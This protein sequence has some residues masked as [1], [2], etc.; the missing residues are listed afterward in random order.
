M[1][2]GRSP[3]CRA[4]LAGDVPGVRH[5]Q[6]AGGTAPHRRRKPR[7]PLRSAESSVPSPRQSA[8]CIPHA[9]YKKV[10][11]GPS[12]HLRLRVSPRGHSPT[13]DALRCS[14]AAE[15]SRR[16]GVA[17]GVATD[18]AHERIARHQRESDRS[19]PRRSRRR[20][21]DNRC[22]AARLSTARGSI[23]RRRSHPATQ[24]RWSHAPDV[25]TGCPGRTVTLR[26]RLRR[27]LR[28]A[29]RTEVGRER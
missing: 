23:G 7:I 2:T 1:P 24:D 22:P 28:H 12:R 13:A 8:R 11:S 25:A 17:T 26:P 3:R 29:H 10:R 27:E 9:L 18:C 14:D 21:C 16:T 19:A 15:G 5:P 4:S 20:C 6:G